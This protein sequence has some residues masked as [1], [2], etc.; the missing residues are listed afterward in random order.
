MLSAVASI[1]LAT[2]IPAK[3]AS[4]HR[5]HR[6]A[7]RHSAVARDCRD[8]DASAARVSTDV[9]RAAVVCLINKERSAHGV[10]SLHSSGALNRAAQAWTDTMVA[11]NSFTEGDPGARISA[12]GFNWSTVGENIAT[13]FRTPR[14]VVAAWMASPSHCQNVLDP[15]YVDVGTGVNKNA[16][17]SFSRRPGTWTQ[18]FGLPMG[19][20]APSHNWGP[21]QH[22][23]Y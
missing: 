18:D 6:H 11:I 12:V 14:Q 17:G 8:A 5:Q 23:P 4:R 2:A 21:A 15:I 10:P 20:R 22:C 7:L 19:R 13:G 1:G 3:A 16:V 9:L